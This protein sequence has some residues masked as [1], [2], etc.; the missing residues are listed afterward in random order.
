VGFNAA[1]DL[2]HARRLI[3]SEAPVDRAVLQDE[4]RR[5][6]D[7][8]KDLAGGVAERKLAVGAA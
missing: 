3:E 6:K 5:M 4:A 2:R 7:L 1:A 8:A